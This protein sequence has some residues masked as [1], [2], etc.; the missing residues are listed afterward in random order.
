MSWTPDL[1]IGELRPWPDAVR[2]IRGETDEAKRYVPEKKCRYELRDGWFVCSS[3]GR[4]TWAFEGKGDPL[5]P[6]RFCPDCGAKVV[7]E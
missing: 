3:C 6:P 7:D 1:I 2:V 5:S 4:R